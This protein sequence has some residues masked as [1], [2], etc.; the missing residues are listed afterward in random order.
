MIRRLRS[1]AV[2]AMALAGAAAALVP[3][4]AASL[5]SLAAGTLVVVAAAYLLVLSGPLASAAPPVTSLDESGAGAATLEPQRLREARRDLHARRAAGSLPT[6]VHER[7]VA[8]G[9][10]PTS[11]AAP[12]PGTTT[13]AAGAAALVHRLLDEDLGGTP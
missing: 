7:L 6:A 9:I 5:A 11:T 4:H 8:A 3:Q 12:A 13:D 10:L 2:A 1:A